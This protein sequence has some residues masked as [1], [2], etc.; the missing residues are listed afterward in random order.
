MQ[1]WGCGPKHLSQVEWHGW[2]RPVAA[3]KNERGGQSQVESAVR[4][5]PGLHVVHL[6]GSAEQVAQVEEQ[7]RH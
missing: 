2:Q 6:T 5:A 3:E 7:G 1:S 4:M